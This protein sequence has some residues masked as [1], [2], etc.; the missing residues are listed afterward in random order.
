MIRD[1][2]DGSRGHLTPPPREGAHRQVGELAPITSS[3]HG[4]GGSPCGYALR[5][6]PIIS[7][8]QYAC[9]ALPRPAETNASRTGRSTQKALQECTHSSKAS[10][11]TPAGALARPH[12]MSRHPEGKKVPLESTSLCRFLWIPLQKL[13]GYCRGQPLGSPNN[14]GNHPFLKNKRSNLQLQITPRMAAAQGK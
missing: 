14:R 3:G 9:V 13:R 7:K 1:P 10:G 2:F 4:L 6:Y 12:G 8:R 5:T 11:A